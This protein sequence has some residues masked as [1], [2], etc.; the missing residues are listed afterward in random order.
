MAKRKG[1]NRKRTSRAVPIGTEHGSS[2]PYLNQQNVP[3]LFGGPSPQPVEGQQSGLQ[4]FASFLD[5]MGG[6]DGIMSTM[7]KIQRM[8]QMARQFGP[9]LKL[10]GS[11][12]NFGSLFG[13]PQAAT[14]SLPPG[15]QASGRAKRGLH[16]PKRP[17]PSADRSA[18]RRNGRER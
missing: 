14:K 1:G 9:M 17:Q 4:G 16:A 8:V 5:R 13:G 7:G 11:F 6:I 12:G 10:L 3:G 2:G 15:R 18:K